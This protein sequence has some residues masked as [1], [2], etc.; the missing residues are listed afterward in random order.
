MNGLFWTVRHQQI[1]HRNQYHPAI[2]IQSCH[3]HLD[4]PKVRTRLRWPH[5]ENFTLNVQLVAWSHRTRPA[6][7]IEAGPDDPA[8]GPEP[9]STSRRMVTAAV[10]QP[11]AT[12]P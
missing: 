1:T 5:L 7:L 11:L 12:R 4:Q 9:P 8:R 3:P 10:C 6:Q 2:L